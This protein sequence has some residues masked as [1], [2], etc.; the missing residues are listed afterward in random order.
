MKT[1]LI[2]G[3]GDLASG[4]AAQLARNGWRILM[5]ELPQP[6]S[7]RCQVSFSRAVYEGSCRVE[8]LEACR[9]D[10]LPA[11]EG[12][13]QGLIGVTVA[14]YREVLAAIRPSLVVDGIMAKHN[15]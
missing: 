6:L 9:V 14:P 1:A 11:W 13:P 3:A 10:G 2:R 8:E 5:T 12:L 15:L 7:V 4:V